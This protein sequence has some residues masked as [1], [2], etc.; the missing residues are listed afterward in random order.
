M[1]IFAQILGFVGMLMNVSSFQCRQQKQ[2]I[3]FQLFGGIIFSVHFWL[4]GAVTGSVLNVICIF[5]ALVFSNKEKAWARWKGWPVVFILAFF[6]MY[7]LNFLAFGME[8]TAYNLIIELLP[9]IGVVAVTVGFAVQSV[10]YT[11]MSGLINSPSWLVYNCI[12]GSIG[13][14]LTEALSLLSILAGILRLDVKKKQT[15]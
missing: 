9:T 10:F 6:T 1:I 11:R 3:R 14:V 12:S 8:P 2:L 7:A 15:E 13:G 5:R 4:L